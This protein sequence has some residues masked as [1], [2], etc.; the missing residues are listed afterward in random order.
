MQQIRHRFFATFAGFVAT[1]PI[2]QISC[3]RLDIFMHGLCGIE[4]EFLRKI[5]NTQATTK[6]EI[7]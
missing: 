6:R 7:A 3:S 2:H 1:D 4:L 5:A